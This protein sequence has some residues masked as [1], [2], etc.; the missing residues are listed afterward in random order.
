MEIRLYSGFTKRINSTKI[1]A[2]H[3]YTSVEVNLKQATNINNPV[4]V[5]TSNLVNFNYVYVP[6]WSRY[7]FV[8]DVVFG[9]NDLIELHCSLD[10]LASFRSNILTYDAF[11]ERTSHPSFYNLDIRDNALSVEDR[12]EHT[13][14]ALTNSPLAEDLLY[15]VRIV[16]RGSTGGVGTFIM[17]RATF[18]RVFSALWGEIDTGSVEGNVLEF[19]Q[20]YIS[21]P[22]E[23]IVGVYT[24]P[25]GMSYY[26][27]YCSTETVYIGGH[28]TTL[29]LDRINA[30][31][32]QLGGTIT[33]NKPTRYYGDFR[34]TDGAF[35]QYTLYI[36]T[37][38]VVPLSPDIM[39]CTLTMKVSADLISGDLFFVLKADGTTIATYNSNC[40]S[41]VSMG[42]LNSAT[43]SF[44]GATQV[45]TSTMTGNPIGLIEGIKT[46]FASTPS[47]IGTQGG[48]G[49]I[50][51]AS[52][53]IISVLQKSS[54]EFATDVYGRPC[55]KYLGLNNLLGFYVKCGNASIDMDG[56]EGDKS[57]VNSQ[58]NAGVY[59]E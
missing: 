31:T 40:Y 27:S 14:E 39:D 50:S 11:V 5:L 1:P 47:V 22:A 20:L 21:N 45:M 24:T 6:S 42:T 53:F 8:N 12:V 3:P 35:S 59:L 18:Q 4:F 16:G 2:N 33:L 41:A 32:V 58:L 15:I 37:V 56:N 38:G 30:G 52:D 9:N 43:S 17:N 36:P 55:C 44:M 34:R 13:A 10:V 23:Y 29:S 54:G 48:T 7:Y 46:G 28:E 26:A 57:E 51:Q 49:C 25:I 19:L